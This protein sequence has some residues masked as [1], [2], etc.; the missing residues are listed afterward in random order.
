MSLRRILFALLLPLALSAC[1]G[2]GGD[3]FAPRYGIQDLALSP[4]GR[5]VAVRFLDRELRRSGFGLYDWKEERFT[6]IP[7][8]WPDRNFSDASFSP[9]GK[10]LVAV[11]GNQ[12]VLIDLADFHV[13]Q[14]TEGGQ[15][16]KETPTFL[17]DGSG[18][19]YVLSNPA[20]FVLLDLVDHQEKQM[21]DPL[22]GFGT[23]SRPFFGAPDRIIFTA[24]APRNPELYVELDKFPD[25]RPDRDVHVYGM[26]FGEQPQLILN[27]LWIEGKKRSRWFAGEGSLQA[28]KDARQIVFIDY[29]PNPSGPG[30]NLDQELFVID[31]GALRQLTHLNAS[32]MAATV[33]YDGSTVAV[34]CD[35]GHSMSHDLCVVEVKTGK[36]RK[37]GLL[38]DLRLN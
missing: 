38:S 23:I 15:G 22:V 1:G 17:P 14:V 3:Y 28:S 21:L 10:R 4:D 11:S 33:S 2:V 18:V 12:I 16:F 36:L 7:S 31:D 30:D 26:K 29:A 37:I 32:L 35:S 27:N 9:D 34:G 5:V 25:S 13:T 24:I 6:P 20:R 19:L 8:P